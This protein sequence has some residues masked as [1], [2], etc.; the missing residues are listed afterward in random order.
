V[1][2]GVVTGHFIPDA[3]ISIGDEE[4][5]LFHAFAAEGFGAGGD[6]D[7]SV[8]DGVPFSQLLFCFRHRTGFRA[9]DGDTTALP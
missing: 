6:F 9:D 4:F 1:A 5:V 8:G 7:V 2:R 3:D